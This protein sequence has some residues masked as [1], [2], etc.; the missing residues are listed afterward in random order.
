MEDKYLRLLANEYPTREAVR[1]EIVNLITQTRLPKGTEYFFSDLHGEQ[2][3]FLYLLRSASG[4]I[5]EKIRTLFAGELSMAEQNQLANLIYTPEKVISLLHTYDRDSRTWMKRTIPHLLLLCREVSSKYPKMRVR[6]KMSEDYRY[7]MEELL[8]PGEEEGK[9]EYVQDVINAIVD[10]ELGSE[11][12]PVICHLIQRLTVDTIHIIGDIF[13]RGPRPDMIMEELISFKDVDI[14]WGNHDI[15]WMGA[16]CG[17]QVL[18]AN[19]VRMGI[20][21]NNFDCLEDGYGINLRPLSAFAQKTYGDDPCRQFIPKVL[22][23]NRYD[24]VD[25]ALA[26]RMHKAISIIQFKLAGQLLHRRPDFGISNR[27]HLEKIDYEKGVMLEGGKQYP[28]LDTHFPTVDPKNPLKLTG[29]EEELM[30]ALSAS[31]AHS[32]TLHRHVRFLYSHGDMY[33]KVNGNLLFHGCIPMK[34][35]GSFQSMRI[36]NEEYS[37]RALLDRFGDIARDAYFLPPDAEK[38]QRSVDWMWY[39]WCGECSPLFGKSKLSAFEHYFVS[40]KSLQKEVMNPYY[41][42]SEKKSVCETIFREFGMDAE[43]SHIIN[44]HVP[45]KIKDGE[46]PIKADGRLYVIDGGLSKAY[47]SKTGIAG[48][49]M[50]FN[51]HYLALAEHHNFMTMKE[52]MDDKLN[53]QITER[54]PQRLLVKDTDAGKEL[55]ERIDDLTSLLEAYTE[56]RVKES[57]RFGNH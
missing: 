56:G 35:D 37:G 21:Y 52:P 15:S 33:K 54:M 44:G 26:A 9:S 16:A 1:G 51:S 50:I 34:S 28:L 17:N 11:F 27:S 5:K 20:S 32:E 24:Q 55:Q 14:Q 7:L 18:I 49:T 4:I 48:Y 57:G 12:I 25:L 36:C 23:K 8:Y 47:Q 42:L 45:V 13:D 43:R 6:S 39:L 29:D 30:T 41:K 3:G 40:D 46:K 31:F 22:D 53:L 2:E 10:N 19:V 38:K